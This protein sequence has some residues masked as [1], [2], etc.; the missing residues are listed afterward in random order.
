MKLELGLVVLTCVI[1]SASVQRGAQ[2]D[3]ASNRRRLGAYDPHDLLKD[4]RVIS[5]E[6]TFVYWQEFDPAQFKTFAS[7]VMQRGRQLMVT[8]EPWTRAVNWKDGR[9][10][11]L[12]DVLKGSFDKEIRSIC[13]AVGTAAGP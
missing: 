4:E 13:Q 8:V 11:L 3:G 7:N 2:A 5:R 12:S 1:L 6:H 9:E 10:A